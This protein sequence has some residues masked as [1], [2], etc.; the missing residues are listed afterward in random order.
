MV[1]IFALKNRCC[2]ASRFVTVEKQS[3]S[4][5]ECLELLDPNTRLSEV[6]PGKRIDWAFPEAAVSTSPRDQ[7]GK[8][9][10]LQFIY[11]PEG[12]AMKDAWESEWMYKLVK[13]H[14][15]DQAAAL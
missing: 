2:T 10:F 13:A 8:H 3:F 14:L 11:F 5:T 6:V 4:F 15:K 1:W 12:M 9:H 7:E